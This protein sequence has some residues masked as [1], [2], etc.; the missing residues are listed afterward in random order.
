MKRPYSTGKVTA[1]KDS[2][3]RA[4][5]FGAGVASR[6][7]W[8]AAMAAAL[9]LGVAAVP[10]PAA[11]PKQAPPATDEPA[12]P[13]PP[14]GLDGARDRLVVVGDG[15]GHYLAMIPFARGADRDHAYWGDGK[16]MH[17]LRVGSSGMSG[18]EW[19]SFVFHDP[20]YRRGV[21]SELRFRDGKYRVSCGS[22]ETE[23]QPLPDADARKLVAAAAWV[24][25]RW[26]WTP[27]ALARDERGTYFYVDRERL[28]ED[29]RN[30][31]LF[32]GPRGKLQR[33][34]MVNVVS[35]SVGEIFVTRS[36]K[37]W[38]VFGKEQS[39]WIKGKNKQPLTNVPVEDNGP[40]IYDESGP[41]AGQRLG[42]PCDDL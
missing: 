17:A 20:R 9:S 8:L 27:Y 34:E 6:R 16:R 37:F 30:F 32:S 28:P 38:L 12:P 29:S 23:L 19:F 14:A 18:D 5:R 26:P 25:P 1:T 35:D 31:R 2:R 41:Y 10:G 33:L 36:G 3:A 39:F 4:G 7:R 24:G 40:L 11:R 21:E 42:T 13:P 22:R 15:R